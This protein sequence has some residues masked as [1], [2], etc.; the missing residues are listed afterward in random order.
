MTAPLAMCHWRHQN[1]SGNSSATTRNTAQADRQHQADGVDGVHSFSTPLTT[2]ASTTNSA[3]VTSTN[4]TSDT[5]TPSTGPERRDRLPA[6]PGN[7]NALS[8]D[9]AGSIT[10]P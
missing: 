1:R 4:T 6:T 9:G 3:T 8:S 7:H 2:R 10:R 5:R